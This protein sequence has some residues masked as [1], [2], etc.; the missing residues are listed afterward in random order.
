MPKTHLYARIDPRIIAV[1]PFWPRD[2]TS[3][4]ANREEL[5]R[6][7]SSPE[8]LQ[9]QEAEAKF[10]ENADSE[11]VA[12]SKGLSLTTREFV[13]SPDG[14]TV[15][16]SVIRPANDEILPCVYFIH[17]GAM[18][19]LSCF[20]GNYRAWGKILATNNVCVVMVDFRNSTIPSSSKEV[21][22]FPAGLNDCVS[23]VTWLHE[24]AS[25]LG[26]DPSRIVVAGESGGG[27]LSIAT[28]LRLKKEGALDLI[29]GIYA[30]CPYINGQWP[31]ERYPSS[32]EYNGLTLELHSNRGAMSYGIEAFN[33][34]NP[35]AWPGFATVDD[36][37]GLPPTV[38]SVNECDPL[39]D[40][41][42]AF[43]RLLFQA[44]VRARGRMVLATTHAAELFP[45]LCPEITHDTARD[46]AA[47]ATQ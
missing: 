33:E 41:G 26:I 46:L 24:Q 34:K 18:A 30:L 31:D 16:V 12:P 11:D 43:L 15:K 36:V 6:E 22:P 44:D 7:A 21:A 19:T 45:T 4:V 29:K 32:S 23:G 39:R 40:E 37:R 2:P 10:M 14:N 20:L 17:G 8:G 47:F 1:E 35:L 5:L 3:N 42:V 38:I 25:S 13:S 9:A 28:G 27:N